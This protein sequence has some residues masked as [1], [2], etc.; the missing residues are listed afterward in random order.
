MIMCVL[1][2]YPV[3]FHMLQLLLTGCPISS[4]GLTSLATHCIG[5]I[6]TG[7]VVGRGNQYIQLVKALYCKLPTNAKQL[8]GFSLCYHSATVAPMSMIEYIAVTA[9]LYM[10]IRGHSGTVVTHW[11]FQS[12]SEL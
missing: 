8:P 3:S 5:H 11:E 4:L 12:C 10:A 1:L 7:S 2:C 9:L 6:M